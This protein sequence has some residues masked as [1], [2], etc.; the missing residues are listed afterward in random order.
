MNYSTSRAYISVRMDNVEMG[1]GKWDVSNQSCERIIENVKTHINCM[2][3]NT[4]TSTK[5]S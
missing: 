2:E 3:E 4:D 1:G 5:E